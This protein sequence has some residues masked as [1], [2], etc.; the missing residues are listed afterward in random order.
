MSIAD[1]ATERSSCCNATVSYS[2]DGELYCKACFGPA[3]WL[4]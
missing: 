4:A 3:E 2:G 1:A